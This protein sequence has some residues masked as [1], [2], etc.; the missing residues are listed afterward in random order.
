MRILFI[1]DTHAPYHHDGAIDF[2]RDVAKEIKPD[3]V[4]HL[5]DELDCHRLSSHPTSP[6]CH[7][8]EDEARLGAE[9]IAELGKLFPRV[10][11]CT[12]NH[13]DRL[14]KQAAKSNIA[15]RFIKAWEEAIDAPRGWKWADSWQLGKV[16]AFHG[17]GYL[18]KGAIEAAVIDAGCNVVFGH[19]HSQ[20]SV[21]YHRR[22]GWTNWG[23]CAGCLIDPESPAMGYGKHHRKKLILGCGVVVDGVPQFRPMK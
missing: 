11:V 17:D 1:P 10:K 16:K 3:E 23:M 20:G 8:P 2:L 7:G 14:H 21:E 5:G 6:E 18:G 12:S 22:S 15:K 13:V 9:F 4:V 19:L